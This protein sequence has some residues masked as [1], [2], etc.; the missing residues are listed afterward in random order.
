VRVGTEA[1]R[2]RERCPVAGDDRPVVGAAVVL[3]DE[4]LHRGGH[5]RVECTTREL[6]RSARL[7]CCG[8]HGQPPL[9]PSDRERRPESKKSWELT[10]RT[11]DASTFRPSHSEL[12]PLR[13]VLD[14]LVRGA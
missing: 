2:P 9:C 3:E 8:G 11:N 14:C 1:A 5:A 10:E 4:E 6:S 13:A 7:L 12:S